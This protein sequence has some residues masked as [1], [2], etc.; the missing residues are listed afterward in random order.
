MVRV[1]TLQVSSSGACGHEAL[2]MG[3]ELEMAEKVSKVLEDW[4]RWFDV[5]IQV[6]LHLH[7]RTHAKA[8]KKRPARQ[9]RESVGRSGEREE[10]W[11]VQKFMAAKCRVMCYV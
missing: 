2:H 6:H 9:E 10:A 1:N 5:S 4:G 11:G 8:H 3:T 7:R